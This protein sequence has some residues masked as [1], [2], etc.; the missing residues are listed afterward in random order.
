MLRMRVCVCVCLR[1]YLGQSVMRELLALLSC[2][3]LL[4]FSCLP[5]SALPPLRYASP[6]VILSALYFVVRLQLALNGLCS[7][8]L[9]KTQ[10]IAALTIFPLRTLAVTVVCVVVVV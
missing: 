5:P 10:F 7:I 4:L 8:Y 1:R 6:L 2:F 9:I 3:F